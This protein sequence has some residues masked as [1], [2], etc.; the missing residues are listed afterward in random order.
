[1]LIFRDVL[2]TQYLLNKSH[3]CSCNCGKL[4]TWR[5][6]ELA[7]ATEWW[8]SL[9]DQGILCTPHRWLDE[10][11]QCAQKLARDNRVTYAGDRDYKWERIF[12]RRH[13]RVSLLLDSSFQ[14]F[15]EPV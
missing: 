3:H 12:W 6:G 14:F 7:I 11:S 15:L 2:C 10:D 4:C 9:F 1:M 5:I 13:D 8:E